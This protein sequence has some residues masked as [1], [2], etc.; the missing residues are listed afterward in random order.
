MAEDED[1]YEEYPQDFQVEYFGF[2]FQNTR[3]SVVHLCETF[4]PYRIVFK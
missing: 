2:F 1:E 4:C 3:D